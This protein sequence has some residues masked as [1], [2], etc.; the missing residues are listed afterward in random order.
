M[1]VMGWKQWVGGDGIEVMGWG[2]G[3]GMMRWE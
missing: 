3:M 1:G 2:N